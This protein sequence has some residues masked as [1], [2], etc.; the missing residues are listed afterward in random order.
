MFFPR[1][2][3][4]SA[5]V[6][7]I[8]VGQPQPQP[9]A[10]TGEGV[11]I[12]KLETTYDFSDDGSAQIDYH[13]RIRMLSDAGVRQLGVAQ[14]AYR[15][16]VDTL[17]IRQIR[18]T[19]PD[20]SVIDTPASTAQDLDAEVTRQAPTY[21]DLREKHVPVRGLGIGDVL[22]W[23]VHVT[24]SS[25]D[26]PGQFWLAHSFTTSTNV[27]DETL[28]VT[29]PEGKYVKTVSALNPAITETAG[30]KKY[31]WATSHSADP[32][33]STPFPRVSAPR[34]S[35]Q[36]TTFKNWN[37]IGAWYLSLLQPQ[38][39]L[40]PAIKTK[41]AELT[42]SLKTD[43]EKL[44]AIY[45]FISLKL[46]YVSISLGVGHYQPHTADD[47]L[48]NQFGDCKD[49]VTLFVALAKAAGIQVLPALVGAGA[50]L[51]PDAPSPAQFNHLI[52]FVPGQ[53]APLWLDTTAS[54]APYGWVSSLLQD[55]KALVI[56]RDGSTSLLPIPQHTSNS[57]EDQ[58]TVESKLGPDGTLAARVE[59]VF[60]S[61]AGVGL[62]N[63]FLRT[64]AV[65]WPS[66]VANI[67]S[68]LGLSAT[69]GDVKVDD[70]T[71]LEAPF[72][73]SYSYRRESYSD[74]SNRRIVVPFPLFPFP[75]AEGK[76]TPTEPMAWGSPTWIY[77][78]TSMELPDGYAPRL[79]APA[80]LDNSLGLYSSTYS[81]DGK[82]LFAS[83]LYRRK[84][85][86]VPPRNW[87]DYQNLAKVANTDQNQTVQL[88]PAALTKLN[89]QA[90]DL[91]R[92]ASASLD[93]HDLKAASDSLVQLEKLDPKTPG[94]WTL[95][96]LLYTGQNQ[97]TKALEALAREIQQHPQDPTP[98][99][100]GA[101]IMGQLG[102]NQEEMALRRQVVRLTP[103][104]RSAYLEL[105]MADL[106]G[107]QFAEAIQVLEPLVSGDEPDVKAAL[108]LT[109]SY[110]LSGKS[111]R[112]D[113]RFSKSGQKRIA[114]SD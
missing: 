71:D 24:R 101:T 37:E 99:K 51:D 109:Q 34:P 103:N 87:A 19:K 38:A 46:R 9:G 83:R 39:E 112:S 29:V 81:T 92:K 61:E 60:R 49:Q 11:T 16:D 59:M 17:Q 73:L 55:R 95:Y 68:G 45:K 36:I 113:W 64:S 104:D 52:A 35:V 40:T 107:G 2:V 114:H 65:Q 7:A 98:Y 90:D 110:L 20:G 23:N 18:V 91:L 74:W 62:K 108:L 77:A 75:F 22:E 102:K 1:F 72:H 8:A 43:D 80:G 48:A 111:D 31:V 32:R 44:R 10:A 88:E 69:A 56:S 41:A 6:F 84:T 26:V 3:A 30:R 28:T 86:S 100:Y 54:V 50:D 70:L 67:S 5:C 96:G 47:V 76:E 57:L 33:A 106:R 93:K 66:L 78:R 94:L 82:T 89:P 21:S 14:F 12:E 53:K 42:G 58:V 27:L 105:A 15:K 25:S 79:P 97:L 4:V 63:L 13:A 85:S